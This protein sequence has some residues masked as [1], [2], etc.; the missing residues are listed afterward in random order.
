[1]RRTATSS[2]SSL[3][4]RIKKALF[5]KDVII[6]VKKSS[7]MKRSRYLHNEVVMGISYVLMIITM[8]LW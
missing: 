7:F 8:Y 4:F 5:I 2:F 6:Y 1:M 3:S